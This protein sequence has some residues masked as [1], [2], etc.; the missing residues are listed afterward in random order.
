MSR[1]ATLILAILALSAGVGAFEAYLAHHH[2]DLQ[3]ATAASLF[4]FSILL[5]AWCKAD[6]SFRHIDPPPAA[7]LLVG[8]F[9]L[10]GI[11]Y[12]FFRILPPVRAAIYSI[13]A[14]GIL[15]VSMFLTGAAY[16]ATLRAYAI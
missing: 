4:P 15:V 16:W 13:F 6:A 14:L 1:R 2:V 11:P 8:M 3:V 10:F 12:Y 9:A 5:F 7:A